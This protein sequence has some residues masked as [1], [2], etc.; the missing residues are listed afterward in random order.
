MKADERLTLVPLPFAVAV[1]Y[2]GVPTS[3]SAYV[4]AAEMGGDREAIATIISAST[5]LSAVTLPVI[6]LLVS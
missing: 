3:A 2:M 4:L 1:V 6:V 5:V